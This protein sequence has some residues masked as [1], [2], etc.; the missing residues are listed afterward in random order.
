MWVENNLPATELNNMWPEYHLYDPNSDY[1]CIIVILGNIF[2]YACIA[3]HSYLCMESSSFEFCFR[4]FFC[5]CY[6]MG[7]CSLPKPT[8][9]DIFVSRYPIT[10]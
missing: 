9:F 7:C 10:E 4:F 1:D 5:R 2:E 3:P 6:L 8:M